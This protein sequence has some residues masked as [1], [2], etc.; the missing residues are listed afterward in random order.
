MTVLKQYDEDS[1]AWETIVVGKQG[2]PGVV[3]ASAPVTYDSGTQTVGIDPV[4]YV[5]AVNG[6]AGTVT[7]DA[8]AVGAVGTAATTD[9]ITEGTANLYN[10]L[11]TG[12]SA[13]QVL[14]KASGTAYDAEWDDVQPYVGG[15]TRLTGESSR[16]ICPG[17]SVAFRGS[18]TVTNNRLHFTPWLVFEPITIDAVTTVVTTAAA[19]TTGRIAVYAAD[20]HFQPTGAPLIDFG[21]FTPTT[22]GAKTLTLGTA[23]TLTTGRYVMLYGI[24]GG[25]PT[26]QRLQMY[27]TYTAAFIANNEFYWDGYI[28]SSDGSAFVTAAPTNPSPYDTSAGNVVPLETLA[29]PRVTT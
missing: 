22:T 6:S 15:F 18:R 5:A 25:G 23:V 19:N 1:E 12:G 10:R 13:G 7:L 20:F 2:P 17:A 9:V 3:A 4:G 21:T 14:T 27:A 28:Y 24:T 16:Y 11:P 29:L 8:A 26:I